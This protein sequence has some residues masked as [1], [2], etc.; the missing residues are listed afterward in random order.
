MAKAKKAA[1]PESVTDYLQ[2]AD[3]PLVNVMEALR[4]VILKTDKEIGEQI[5]WN[6]PAFYY[7]GEM[8]PF[9]PKEYKRDI[10]VF[11]L[12]KKE[13]ILVIF[14]T[15]AKI[16]DPNGVLEGKFTDGRRMI[17]IK[18]LGEVKA[19]EKALQAVIKDWLKQVEKA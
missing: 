8:K 14:P 11:N 15:G 2:K 17:T 1:V 7:T 5:K 6:S 18:D 19:K 10:I 13:Y 3:H 12:H 16:K 9:D 4:R